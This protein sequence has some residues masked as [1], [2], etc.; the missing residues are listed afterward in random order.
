MKKE[1]VI[2]N[3]INEKDTLD[4]TAG[5]VQIQDKHLTNQ[6]PSLDSHDHAI[7][8]EDPIVQKAYDKLAE[9]FSKN[10]EKALMEA[11]Q[12]KVIYEKNNSW[13]NRLN[14]FFDSGFSFQIS[15]Y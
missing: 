4:V 7:E 8:V 9:V 6:M 15:S 1:A 12:Y 5:T 11:G 10:Y 2:N 14:W 3:K 13:F